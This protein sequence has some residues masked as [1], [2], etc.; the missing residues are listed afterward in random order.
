MYILVQHNSSLIA[1]NTVI[2]MVAV[3]FT[4]I[5]VYHIITYMCGG[6]IRDKIQQGVNTVMG[7]ILTKSPTDQRFELANIPEVTFN[8]R[9][10]QEPLVA[11][12][13]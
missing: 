3:H 13:H 8:Y 9:E 2:A 7:W 10:Y 6:V 4:L 11:Q 12:D 5:V 1:I